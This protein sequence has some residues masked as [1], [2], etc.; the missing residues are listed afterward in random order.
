MKRS[1]GTEARIKADEKKEGLQKSFA[2]ASD[3]VI[4]YFFLHALSQAKLGLAEQIPTNTSQ[5][6]IFDENWQNLQ[7]I[8]EH[9]K[10]YK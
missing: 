1:S 8:A 5:R 6:D 3:N 10:G 2:I 9:L 7:Y 4:I